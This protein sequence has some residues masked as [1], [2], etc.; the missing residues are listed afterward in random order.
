MEH[1]GGSTQATIHPLDIIL[2]SALQVSIMA[3]GSIVALIL[4]PLCFLYYYS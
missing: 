1:I 4:P 3:Q 2:N